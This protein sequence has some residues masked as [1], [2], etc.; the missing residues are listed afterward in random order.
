MLPFFAQA[1]STGHVKLP[2]GSQ[3]CDAAGRPIKTA[4]Q[5]EVLVDMATLQPI[6]DSRGQPVITQPG[7]SY[8]LSYHRMNWSVRIS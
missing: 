5:Q 3:L 2:D 7:M 4:S 6:L 1:D 8:Y